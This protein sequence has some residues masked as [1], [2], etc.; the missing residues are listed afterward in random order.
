MVCNLFHHHLKMADSLD[1]D[2]NPP[3]LLLHISDGFIVSQTLQF[4]FHII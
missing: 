1:N 4:W 3:G 2:D